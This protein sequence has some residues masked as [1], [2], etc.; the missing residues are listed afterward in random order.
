MKTVT[1]NLDPLKQQTN[2]VSSSNIKLAHARP[3]MQYIPLVY[4]KSTVQLARVGPA[5]ACPNY[6]C[7]KEIIRWL[8]KM[9]EILMAKKCTNFAL[10]LQSICQ[11]N[12]TMHCVNYLKQLLLSCCNSGTFEL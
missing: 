7:H 1:F 6:I 3:T 2:T 10:L 8:I 5:Q 9:F 12:A 4:E 11:E